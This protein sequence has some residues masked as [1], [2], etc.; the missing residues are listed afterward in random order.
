MN[1]RFDVF[2]FRRCRQDDVPSSGA[3]VSVEVLSPGERARTLENDIHVQRFP[4]QAEQRQPLPPNREGS[5]IVRFDRLLIASVD[6][7]VFQEMRDTVGRAYVVGGD[8]VQV[9]RVHHDLE[10]GS[11]DSSQSVDGDL[12][13]GVLHC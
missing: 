5:V 3:N 8:Q 4:R 6:G 11:T 10:C 13:H 1:D 9:R 2:A 12:G 7:V